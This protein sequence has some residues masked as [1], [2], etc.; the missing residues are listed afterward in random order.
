MSDLFDKVSPIFEYREE[1]ATVFGYIHNGYIRV[2]VQ[3][4]DADGDEGE[5]IF[6]IHPESVDKLIEGLARAKK[7]MVLV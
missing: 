2:A 6:V 5:D 3:Y 7:M 1:D 4:T